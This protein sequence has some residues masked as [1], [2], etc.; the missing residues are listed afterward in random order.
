[1]MQDVF[2]APE[3]RIREHID[4][5][6]SYYP[7]PFAP[8]DVMEM[9]RIASLADRAYGKLSG[10]QKRQVQFALAICGHPRL[11]FL[12]EP[13]VGLD[14]HARQ[15][16][17]CTL[18]QLVDQGVSIVLTTHYLEE[19]EAL[20]DRVIVLAQ[21]RV[22]ASGTVNEMRALVIRKHI[23]CRSSLD[24]EEVKRWPTVES[25]TLVQDE[26]H[27]ATGDAEAIIQR[28]LAVDPILSDLDVRRAGLAEVVTQLTEEAR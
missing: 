26:L 27:I 19:A 25:A 12:D 14:V 24:V 4:L 9:T 5:I 20:A 6:T 1:M 7:D 23:R 15:T 8:N 3:L 22:I 2:L 21:G 16:T 10:G 11:L 13:T 28:L 17:W 18:R